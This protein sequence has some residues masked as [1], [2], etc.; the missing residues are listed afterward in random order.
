MPVHLVSVLTALS[1]SNAYRQSDIVAPSV[2][3][4]HV[5]SRGCEA[6]VGTKYLILGTL[7]VVCLLLSVLASWNLLVFFTH[8]FSIEQI[9]YMSARQVKISLIDSAVSIRW[10]VINQ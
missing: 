4:K 9:D 3:C 1:T 10:S 8:L 7:S 6:R 2:S 5:G